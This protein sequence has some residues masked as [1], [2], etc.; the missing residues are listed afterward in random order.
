MMTESLSHRAS[1]SCVRPLVLTL[2]AAAALVAAGCASTPTLDDPLAALAN[3][4]N[5]PRVHMAAMSALDARPSDDAYLKTLHRV[6]WKAGYTV[7]AREAAVQ[8]LIEYD[9]EGLKRTLRQHLPRMTA[10]AGLTR[11]C[12]IIAEQGWEDLS[13]ALV[14]SWAR[15]TAYVQE[16]TERPEYK[17]LARL[18]GPE[19]VPDVVFDLLITSSKV[20][21]QGLRTRCWDLLHRLGRRERLV[22]MLADREIPDD[23]AF[24]LDLQA[25]A[26]ELGLVPHNREEILWL[27]KLRQP[28]RRPFWDEAVAALG[29]L[30]AARRA[31]L[32]FRDIPIVVSAARHEP[33]LL[34]M[35]ESAIYARLH[36]VLA[37][38]KHHSRGS[39]WD[40]QSA[41]Q[42][43]RLYE[44]RG[45]LTWGDLAAMHV[46]L[47]ALQV[48]QVVDHL[49]DYAERDRAD[50]TTEYGG[51]IALDE[52]GRF[53]I[54][55]FPPRIRQHDQKFIA[56]Q[57]MLDAAYTSL[58]HFHMHVQRHWNR[59][60]AGPGFGDVN[61]AD[62]TRANCLVF[63]FVAED[64]MNVD[65]YRHGRVM[66]DLG[67]IRR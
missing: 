9:L 42:R 5:G 46:A 65:Y 26:A 27:R 37:G 12:E 18:F 16:E 38:R 44:W 53:E 34:A 35:D 48:P 20:Y 8:R 30:T 41:N 52:R 2:L 22:N 64:A 63:T 50:E 19:N 1:R 24:M 58:F 60:Y 43:E 66:V 3:V 61:Y 40:N 51:V 57:A 67:E 45:E 56:S 39:N 25:G 36:A 21:Q 33:E 54:L 15:P 62:N 55:E 47:R 29:Q 10:W 23:D 7:D 4:E 59:Q 13:P 31:A 28:E 11:L 32:E 6:V 17:A 14:S 49:F